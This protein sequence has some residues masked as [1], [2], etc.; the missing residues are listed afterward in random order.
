ML[1][2]FREREATILKMR[3]GFSAEVKIL[4]EVDQKNGLS[5]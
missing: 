1:E 2:D 3:L 5:G 4:E